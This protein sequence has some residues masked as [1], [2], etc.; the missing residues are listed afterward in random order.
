M[1]V[2]KLI[3]AIVALLC[4]S[5]L[6]VWLGMPEPAGLKERTP[7]VE[8]STR[9]TDRPAVS[10]ASSHTLETSDGIPADL[11]G[12]WPRFRGSNFD[13]VA[14]NEPDLARTWTAGGPPKLWSVKVGDG[15]A[16]PAVRAGRV[17]VMDYDEAA[18]R[19]ALRCLSLEDGKEIWRLSYPVDV[20]WNYGMSRTVPA[21]TDKW[22]VGF[23]P[24]C[25]VICADAAT[26]AFKWALDLPREFGVKVPSWY[27]GQC[28]LIDR[29]RAII[30]VAGPGVLMMAVD[31]ETGKVVWKTPN[32]SQWKMTHSSIIP[33]DLGGVRMYLYPASDGVVAVSADDGRVLW[34]DKTWSTLPANVPCPILVDGG[35]VFLTAGYGAGSRM[36]RFSQSDGAVTAKTLFS[37][38]N[39]VFAA[40]QHTPILHNDHIYGVVPK[41][42]L[43]CLDLTGRR[44]WSS[45]RRKRFG[46]GP[47]IIANGLLFLMNDTGVLT[48]AEATPSGYRQL[49]EAK[50]LPA[51]DKEAWAP[52]A[53][54][55]GRLI[56]RDMKQMIC[57][58]VRRK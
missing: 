18:R 50:V 33:F 7:P 25:H 24:L 56:L 11:P 29:G 19:D 48:L 36:F 4:A 53:I 28:P 37:L 57:L 8:T 34:Q 52:M 27:A 2:D 22:A 5:S 12:S 38:R 20:K 26:G 31:C 21:V 23:G 16:G 51:R 17:Y 42:D 46:R 15:Y 32:P 49:A 40:E 14:G 39:H 55:G 3:P 30:A 47:S 44:V 6:V 41:G 54:A 58:D 45:G 35:R 13:A 9:T 10:I 1:S 43:V